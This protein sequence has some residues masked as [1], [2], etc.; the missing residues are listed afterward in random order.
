M[1]DSASSQP[2]GGTGRGCSPPWRVVAALV[3]AAAFAAA[4]VPGL[5]DNISILA[6]TVPATLGSRELSVFLGLVYLVLYA[7]AVLIVPTLVT[8][9][10][11]LAAVG[12]LRR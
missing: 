8:A 4:H 11:M 12:M 5:R 6:G 1:K 10:G 2:A 7:S 9:A 3:I